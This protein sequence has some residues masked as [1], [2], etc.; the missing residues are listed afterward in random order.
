M[1]NL[2]D[3]P[4]KCVFAYFF[5]S[6]ASFVIGSSVIIVLLETTAVM[7]LLK[8]SHSKNK[9]EKDKTKIKKYNQLIMFFY[10]I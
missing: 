9:F 3:R 10:L 7:L 6:L 4:V 8:T 1:L 5:K 2:L